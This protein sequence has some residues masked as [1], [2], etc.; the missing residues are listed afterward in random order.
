MLSL[1]GFRAKMQEFLE[2]WFSGKSGR[3]SGG[4]M[5]S[6]AWRFLYYLVLGFV[7][8]CWGCGISFAGFYVF[9]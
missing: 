5:G 3:R 7:V 9:V 4:C 8:A 1:R 6:K 2:S